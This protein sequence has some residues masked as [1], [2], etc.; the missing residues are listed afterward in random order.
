MD[1]RLRHATQGHKGRWTEKSREGSGEAFRLRCAGP[2]RPAAVLRPAD[3]AR[4]QPSTSA[5]RIFHHSLM[6]K[7][8]RLWTLANSGSGLSPKRVTLYSL[9]ARLISFR[10]KIA[11]F[12][13]SKRKS[14]LADISVVEII[15]KF[16]R[17]AGLLLLPRQNTELTSSVLNDDVRYQRISSCQYLGLGLLGSVLLPD[18][19][20][21]TGTTVAMLLCNMNLLPSYNCRTLRSTSFHDLLLDCLSSS[22]VQVSSLA[23]NYGEV[24]HYRHNERS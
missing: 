16:G 12:I 22:S 7:R 5:S 19:L 8:K 14:K 1:S 20:S 6:E 15:L 17:V 24:E 4:L 2:P 21:I 23:S 9:Q 10:F 18:I 3:S 11:S 13:L